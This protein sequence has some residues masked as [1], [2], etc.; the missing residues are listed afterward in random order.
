[1]KKKKKKKFTKKKKKINKKKKNSF[2]AIYRKWVWINENLYPM[3][4]KDPRN[5]AS[6]LKILF[7]KFT[8]K[9][10]EET[11][12]KENVDNDFNL[13]FELKDEKLIDC[14]KKNSF[15]F[16]FNKKNKNK[17]KLKNKK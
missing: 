10:E 3:I 17:K 2:E 14:K 12:E 11:F 8:E 15:F 4:S 6:M 16:V 7:H 5:R 1:M 13:L 9:S